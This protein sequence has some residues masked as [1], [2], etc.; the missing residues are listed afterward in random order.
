MDNEIQ[1]FNFEGVAEV[2]TV[3]IG[4]EPWF[5][6]G[7]VTRALGFGNPSQA[8]TDHVDTEDLVKA[9]I[10]LPE[11]S[12]KVKRERPLINESGVYALIFG[13]KLESAKKFKRWVTAEVL[14]TIRKTGGA[15]VKPGSSIEDDLT[16]GDPARMAAA[17][18]RIAEV[19][20]EQAERIRELEPKAET[21]DAFSEY[22]WTRSAMRTE[23]MRE[24]D[25]GGVTVPEFCRLLMDLGI[26][27]EH[28]TS[29]KGY[30]FTQEYRHWTDQYLTPENEDG[31]RFYNTGPRFNHTGRDG[32][33]RMFHEDPRVEA[34]IQAL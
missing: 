6:A 29:L 18:S 32:L 19:A 11:G 17:A 15:Y 24:F 23:V 34:A 9:T 12:R 30:T 21:G 10:R 14:P 5:V 2:R 1:I 16:S 27:Q 31:V 33:L 20:R 22:G 4:G 13:S 3:E 25:L 7:D 8:L 28:P 26:T